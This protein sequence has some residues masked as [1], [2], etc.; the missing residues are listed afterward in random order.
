MKQLNEEQTLNKRIRLIMGTDEEVLWRGISKYKADNQE[1][2]DYGIT[3]DACFPVTYLEKALVQYNI[4]SKETPDFK[5]SA[6]VAHN[7][8]PDSAKLIVDGEEKIFSGKTAHAM[9]P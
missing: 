8:V 3:P 2:I 6:G 1:H 5:L 7:A 4:T 9:E